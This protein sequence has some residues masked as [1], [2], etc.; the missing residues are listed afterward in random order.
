MNPASSYNN[1]SFSTGIT[2]GLV[3]CAHWC[4]PYEGA[5]TRL[6]KLAIVN[7]LGARDL[8]MLL[9]GK[10]L[11]SNHARPLHGRSLLAGAWMER[12]G[13][14]THLPVRFVMLP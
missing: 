10:K 5:Y 12:G 1:S 6:G 9:F 11:L 2:G 8:S 7:V 4:H 3:D 13:R 14:S